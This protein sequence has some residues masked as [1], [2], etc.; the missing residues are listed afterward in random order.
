MKQT[1]YIALIVTITMIGLQCNAKDKLE[2]Q[3]YPINYTEL[4]N[5]LV[6]S[7]MVT[8]KTQNV[9]IDNEEQF[10]KYFEEAIVMGRNG[11][12]PQ[13]DFKTQ[14][15]LAV[16]L[17]RTNRATAVIPG[18]IS[19]VGNTVFFNYR[20]RKGNKQE[21]T[22]VPFTAVIIDKP[23]VDTQMEFIFKKK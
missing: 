17:P 19:Q 7:H 4:Q 23:A 18:E 22:V 21:Y 2:A 9:I 12:A 15:V 1:I 6:K 8:K 13:V 5:Y 11:Q 10:N 3:A 20:V 16:I 14:Y